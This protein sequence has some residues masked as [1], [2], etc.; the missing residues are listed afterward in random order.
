MA[1]T[2]GNVA[3][4]GWAKQSAKGTAAAASI[5]K[6]KFTG[7]DLTPQRSLSRLAE[8]SGTRDQGPTIVTAAS[9]SGNAVVLPPLERLLGLRVLRPRRE[10]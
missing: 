10:R 1:G 8:T 4:F 6:T 5:R 7:G 3:T 9:V 2:S